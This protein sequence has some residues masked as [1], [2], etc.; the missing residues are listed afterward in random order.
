MDYASKEERDAARKM[1]TAAKQVSIRQTNRERDP[2]TEADF[3]R[4]VGAYLPT[5]C[6]G[7]YRKAEPCIE[8]PARHDCD[9]H[10]K[11]PKVRVEHGPS[12]G[13]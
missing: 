9:E 6:P 8:C 13:K 3:E 2:K 10:G 5:D 1:E 4:L 11:P 7:E 12:A